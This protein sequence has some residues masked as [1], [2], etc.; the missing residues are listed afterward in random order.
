M[1][2]KPVIVVFGSR[3]Y[4]R[5]QKVY[6]K[7]FSKKYHVVLLISSKNV[8]KVTKDMESFFTGVIDCNFESTS[9]VSVAIRS[10][11]K[12]YGDVALVT[13]FGEGNSRRL[14]QIVPHVPYCNTAS[15]ES[16]LW[17]TNKI[18]MRQRLSEYDQSIS[19][20]FF[21]AKDNTESTIKK[22]EK[23]V[24]YPLIVKPTNM[25]TSTFVT[26]CY[27]R[28]ELEKTLQLLFKKNGV[29]RMIKQGVFS[30]EV[31]STQVIVEEY[32]EGKMYSID[33]LVDNK[34]LIHTY[35]MVHVKTGK[36]IGFDDF[37]GYQRITP[38]QVNETKQKLAQEVVNKTVHAL[39][40]RCVHFH[41]E[42]MRLED[43]WKIIEITP[44]Q[45]GYRSDMYDLAYGV[46][47]T[48]NEIDMK[49]HGAIKVEEKK[50]R[51]YCAVLQIFAKQEGF[52]DS[53]K[54]IKSIKKLESIVTCKQKLQKDGRVL[55]AKNGGKSVFDIT[56][57]N[58]NRAL[59]L[60]DIRRIEK[61]LQIAVRK[62]K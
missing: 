16:L 7:N 13:T 45:G 17:S 23:T 61:D 41:A 26:K 53:I 15:S 56:L 32:M 46:D 2:R 1:K 10:I 58:K 39:R 4:T 55:F 35:P 24:S 14:A 12:T 50:P 37:F 36:E 34:G 48:K 59:L 9:S 18:L 52:I 19:P 49:L 5:V 22:I 8:S 54:G 30:N 27:H 47:I 38:V 43:E 40:L 62:K 57:F 28:D 11:E 31:E 21:I 51:G 3:Q 42:L 20:S 25:A 29:L 60:A 44:R 6:E 33:G